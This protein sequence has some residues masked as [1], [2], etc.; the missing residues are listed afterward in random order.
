MP[1]PFQSPITTVPPDWGVGAGGVATGAVRK[2]APTHPVRP[3]SL[4]S[5]WRHSEPETVAI[6]PVDVRSTVLW[7]SRATTGLVVPGR[8]GRSTSRRRPAR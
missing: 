6:R 2:R 3:E 7:A 8:R 4:Y 1:S 5:T